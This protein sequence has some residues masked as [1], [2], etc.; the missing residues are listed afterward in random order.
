MHSPDMVSPCPTEQ[1]WPG[2][3]ASDHYLRQRGVFVTVD[4]PVRGPILMM[5]G[6]PIRMSASSVPILLSALLGRHNEE[7]YG[8]PLGITAEGLERLRRTGVI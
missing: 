1:A 8:S 7:V 3:G 4:H 5:P 6:C 2:L